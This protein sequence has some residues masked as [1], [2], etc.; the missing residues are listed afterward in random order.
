MKTTITRT[1]NRV[2]ARE[3]RTRRHEARLVH[4]LRSNDPE[5]T[6]TLN[7]RIEDEVRTA[8]ERQ[9]QLHA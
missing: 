7:Y 4:G 5:S 3:E 1:R 6:W 9:Q 2:S 8:R